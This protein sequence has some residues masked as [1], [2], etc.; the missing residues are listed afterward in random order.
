MNLKVFT[1][2]ITFN[3]TPIQ[4]GRSKEDQIAKREYFKEKFIGLRKTYNF[5]YSRE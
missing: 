5:P 1:N 4:V 3:K 2:N